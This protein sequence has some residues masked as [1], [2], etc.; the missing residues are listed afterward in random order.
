MSL[1]LICN[2]IQ[3]VS[4]LGMMTVRPAFVGKRVEKVVLVGVI[5]FG[6]FYMFL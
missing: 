6:C 2:V 5:T 1:V 3:I 4:I